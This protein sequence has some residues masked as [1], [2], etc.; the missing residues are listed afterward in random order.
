MV[1]AT[2]ATTVRALALGCYLGLVS[3]AAPWLVYLDWSALRP[4]YA[5]DLLE[6][7]D[8]AGGAVELATIAC[9]LLL[10][11]ALGREHRPGDAR[12]HIVIRGPVVRARP[13]RRRPRDPDA[14]R[15]DRHGRAP[16]TADAA[17]ASAARPDRG[18]ALEG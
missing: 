18:S 11:A 12:R 2:H 10:V 3:L 9:E 8:N 14:P 4:L 17:A 6:H 13:L 15:R 7:V 1:T 5:W 16:R